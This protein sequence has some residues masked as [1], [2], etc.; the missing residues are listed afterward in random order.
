MSKNTSRPTIADV[1]E[2]AGYSRATVSM[3]LNGKGRL[4][5]STRAKIRAVADQLGYR[6]SVRAQ[7]LRG[8]RSN[9][10]ALITSLPASI[11]AETSHYGF[12]LDLAMPMAQQCL[13]HG[14]SLLLVPPLTSPRD[15]ALFDID[16]AVIDDPLADDPITAELI[17]RGVTVVTIG[18][19]KGVS[20]HGVVDRAYSGGDIMIKHLSRQGA[21]HVAV[22]LSQEPHSVAT[23]VTAYLE[24]LADEGLPVPVVT[25][26]CAADGEQGGYAVALELLQNHPEIDAIYASM[27]AFAVGALRA[28][29][30]LGLRVPEDVMIG[31]NYNG[32]RSTTASPQLTALDLN[33]TQLAHSAMT[34]LHR[35]LTGN[36]GP[37]ESINGPVPQLVLRASTDRSLSPVK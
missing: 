26:A 15:L 27:D 2:S 34:L 19:S 18:R 29:R 36:A 30:H 10:I 12:L 5:T 21:Q 13:S 4:D 35:S 16:G 31:T 32:A 1:A 20:A 7:R 14:Y 9:T 24:T 8:G 37:S 11:V 23:S 6:P 22:I 25:Y 3:A 28:I 17:A 33:F